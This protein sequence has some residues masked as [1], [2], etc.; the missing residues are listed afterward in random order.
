MKA[1]RFWFAP[2]GLR[3][4]LLA[5][6]GALYA[7][8]TARR[9]RRGARGA[10]RA[11][12]PVLCVGNLEAGGAGKTPLTAYLA[13]ALPGAFI[14]SRGY[15]GRLSGPLQVDPQ[16]HSAGEVG[17]EPLFLAQ[18]AP[19]VVAKDRKAGAQ[20]ALAAGAK[21]LI[22]DDGFQDPSLVKDL[23][24][25]VVD[26]SRGWGNGLCLPA[27]PLREPPQTGLARADFLLS[28]GP[29]EAQARFAAPY[30]ALPGAP[31]RLEGALVPLPMGMDWAGARLF[32]FA[33]IGA[34]EK[35]FATLR[36]LGAD[37]CGAV[38]L[39]DHAPLAPALLQRL[40]ARAQAEGAELVTTE[41]DAMRLPPAWRGRVLV[42]P[43][44]LVLQDAA[45]LAARLSGLG[46]GQGG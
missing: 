16:H 40:A 7:A 22:L 20:A 18:N 41:K 15:G 25:L 1:P 26:A 38:A 13:A 10:F 23:S 2:R 43:V 24:I 44:R 34:P 28:L 35:F 33:G 5:P 11:P 21:A 31:P 39:A 8:G 14:V 9:L 37:L 30:A 45:P 6:L 46:L 36:S 29:A 32:A 17:D 12:V 19:V 3:A 27:G 42:L 4:W